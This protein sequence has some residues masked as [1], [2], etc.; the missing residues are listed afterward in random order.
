MV[1]KLLEREDHQTIIVNQLKKTEIFEI[2]GKP[3]TSENLYG[4]SKAI[5][6]SME[7]KLQECNKLFAQMAEKAEKIVQMAL[8]IVEEEE[9]SE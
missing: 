3:K 4:D 8:N 2:L 7:T 9:K 6:L 5:L 1:E